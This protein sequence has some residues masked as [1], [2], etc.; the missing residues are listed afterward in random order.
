[1]WCMRMIRPFSALL[2][3]LVALATSISLAWSES[4]EPTVRI[5]PANIQTSAGDTIQITIEIHDVANLGA[6]Q[7]DL[8]YDPAIVQ[9][10]NITLGDF[11]GSTGRS[12]NP[13]GP[14]IQAGKA[15]YG[16]FSFGD[17]A[18]PDGSGALATVTLKAL[19]GGQTPL[20]LGN[21][22]VID[23][24]G[25]RIQASTQGAAV[26]VSGSP[27]APQSTT[28]TRNT[29]PTLA[30]T[31]TVETLLATPQESANT[32]IE[33]ASPLKDWVIT[34]AALVAILSLAI[35]AARRMAR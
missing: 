16:A 10:D 20:G 23:I 35:L 31:A 6:F 29:K 15:V 4:P 5:E 26:T 3:T 17:A 13:L 7:F 28:V 18:G 1:L 12:V 19:A 24:G 2:L 27:A 32:Q 22:Q 33:S 25:A 30:G 21:V 34:A 9:V 8:T 14:K 11:P